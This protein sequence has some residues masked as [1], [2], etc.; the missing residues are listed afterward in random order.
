VKS[1]GTTTK[2]GEELRAL[3][4]AFISLMKKNTKE[5]QTVF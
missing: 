5:K 2:K 4:F 3:D 1:C